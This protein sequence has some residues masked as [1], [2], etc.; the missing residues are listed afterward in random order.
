M[1][2]IRLFPVLDKDLCKQHRYNWRQLSPHLQI[3]AND[4]CLIYYLANK[5]QANAYITQQ[6]IPLE[7]V[8]L[9]DQEYWDIVINAMQEV[10][11]FAT[12]NC[13]STFGRNYSYTIAAKTG[14]AQVFQDVAIPMKKINKNNLPEKLR[15]HHLFI[16]FAPVDK[17]KIALAI[18][19]EN[20][21]TAIETARDHFRL[22]FRQIAMQTC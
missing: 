5:Y 15:D 14:T 8:T 17:P 16:A 7:S 20:S 11:S 13:L 6:P 2:A 12:R 21:N 9:Q 4:L 1:L 22:L 10:V 18:I 19:T 3:A